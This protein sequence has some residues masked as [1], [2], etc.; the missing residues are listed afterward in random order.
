MGLRSR[1]AAV[2]KMDLMVTIRNK[3]LR[4]RCLWNQ[5]REKVYNGFRHFQSHGNHSIKIVVSSRDVCTK[6]T[7]VGKYSSF[8]VVGEHCSLGA[9]ANC[10][11]MGFPLRLYE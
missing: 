7:G 10:C 11:L 9:S 5:E 3:R 8:Q 4:D 2:A 1:K 6:Q